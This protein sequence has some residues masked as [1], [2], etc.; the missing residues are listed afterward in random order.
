MVGKRLCPSHNVHTLIPGTC[1]CVTS[2]CGQFRLSWAVGRDDLGGLSV[3]KGLIRGES[4]QRQWR[5][6]M[7]DTEGRGKADWVRN[8]KVL[9]YWL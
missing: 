5:A 3:N 4:W 7:A 8:L 9:P 2:R 1:E 6:I